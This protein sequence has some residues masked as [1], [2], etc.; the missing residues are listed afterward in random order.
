LLELG[1]DTVQAV[2]IAAE[3]RQQPGIIDATLRALF[4]LLIQE[5]DDTWGPNPI[6]YFVAAPDDPMQLETFTVE[7][8]S[9]PPAVGEILVER[10]A[11]DLLGL[12]V[13]ETIVV[14]APDGT[15]ASLRISGV[16]HTP[17][18]TPAFQEQRG[19]A[20][21]STASLTELG[22]P[23]ALD[24]LKIQVADQPV[25][26]GRVRDLLGLIEAAGFSQIETEEMPFPRFHAGVGFVRAHKD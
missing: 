17:G 11:L 25:R 2:A 24:S 21:M 3:V 15:P 5:E 26:F 23:V 1:L 12:E 20:F 22:M 4:T 7:Q 8:G 19:H 10:S 16:V 18:L 13:G 9:W 14:Q 6:Q